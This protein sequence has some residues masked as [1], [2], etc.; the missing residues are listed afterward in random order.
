M[1]HV[2]HHLPSLSHEYPV[3]FDVERP[4]R[5]ERAQVALRLLVLALLAVFS[6]PLGWLFGVLYL[7]LPAVAAIGISSRGAEGFTSGMS[8]DIVRALRWVLS[9]YAYLFLLTDRF[10]Q[11]DV[12][13]SFVR[14]EVTPSGSP[15]VG[16]AL[17]RLLFTLP[18]AIVLFV[19]SWAAAIVWVICLV[20]ALISGGMLPGL[21][22]FLRGVV[23][24]Q[25]RLFAYHASLVEEHPPWSLDTEALPPPSSP[26][27]EVHPESPDSTLASQ[28]T[29]RRIE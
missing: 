23:R 28:A 2:E 19:L 15:T 6:A 20:S 21:Y 7:A 16:S 11:R 17:L 24:W 29:A 13:G 9:F 25:A 22:D 3:I 18:Y 4:V 8:K 26:S 14:F 5:Y 10:P 27:P 12:P 1:E